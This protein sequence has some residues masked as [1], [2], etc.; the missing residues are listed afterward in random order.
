MKIDWLKL[1]VNILNDSKI[2]LI[3]NYPDGDKLVVLWIGLL[4]LAMKS[5]ES[6]LIYVTQGIPFSVT[7]LS[8]EFDIEIKTVELGLSLFRQYNMIEIAQGGT[9]EIINFEKHQ[10]LD[11]IE[12]MKKLTNERVRKFR[13]KQKLI[14]NV[15]ETLRNADVTQQIRLDKIR[16]DKNKEDKTIKPDKP[17]KPIE[18]D[19]NFITLYNAYPR[20]IGKVLAYKAYTARI[21]EGVLHDTL[22]IA[23]KNYAAEVGRNRTDEKYI[24]HPA[25]F[26]GPSA[27][28]ADYGGQKEVNQKPELFCPECAAVISKNSFCWN[29][30]RTMKGL[31]IKP[32]I[33]ELKEG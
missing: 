15:T 28:Y 29:C 4:C 10:S 11:R 14:C 6:G 12:N 19:T 23:V 5:N 16:L 20:H 32:K 2:K 30:A 18:T 31:T 9:I 13:D 8:N 26:L 21:K 25:T 7:D 24:M 1:D 3:R 27:R 33:E 17:T 22:V